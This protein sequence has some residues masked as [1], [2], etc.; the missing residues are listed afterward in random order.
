MSVLYDSIRQKIS[1]EGAFG[2]NVEYRV[3]LYND[4][5]QQQSE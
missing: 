5:T 2:L 3:K 4:I 1:I